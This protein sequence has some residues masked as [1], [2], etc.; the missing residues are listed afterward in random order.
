[1]RTMSGSVT[2]D[3]AT[4]VMGVT[5]SARTTVLEEVEVHHNQMMAGVT[6]GPLKDYLEGF[7]GSFDM[8]LDVVTWSGVGRM[9]G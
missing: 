5:E 9:M 3:G 8:G 7:A 4:K 2:V 1:M 6:V